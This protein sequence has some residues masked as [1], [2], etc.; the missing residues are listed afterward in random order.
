VSTIK[1]RK[2]SPTS[3]L[4]NFV[5]IRSRAD[6]YALFYL[7]QSFLWRSNYGFAPAGGVLMS[8]VVHEE[9]VP[10][11]RTVGFTDLL[12]RRHVYRDVLV[13]ALLHPQKTVLSSFKGHDCHDCHDTVEKS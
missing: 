9:D 5:K 10:S 4:Q 3:A 11:F 2:S 13:I 7:K 8:S 12:L 1:M 6:A